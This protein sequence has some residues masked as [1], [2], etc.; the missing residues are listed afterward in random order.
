MGKKEGQKKKEGRRIEKDREN[1]R[2]NKGHK[3]HRTENEK[4]EMTEW[5]IKKSKVY[6]AD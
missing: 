5:N 4:S 1:E 6:K 2:I 3:I